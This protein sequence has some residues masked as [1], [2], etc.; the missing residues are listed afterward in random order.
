MSINIRNKN[1]M[2]PMPASPT[3][4]LRSRRAVLSAGVT[5]P[6][7]TASA[8][9]TSIQGPHGEAPACRR[10]LRRCSTSPS[11]QARTSPSCAQRSPRTR[12]VLP[13]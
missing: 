9:A 8:L 3:T 12:P 1:V 7:W 10:T 13:G 11:V 4:V 6:V 5:E 2:T